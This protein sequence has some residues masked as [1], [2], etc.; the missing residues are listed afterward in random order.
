MN[1]LL[2][3][4]AIAAALGA[5]SGVAVERT[6]VE[7]LA[8][9]LRSEVGSGRSPALE[10]ERLAVGGCAR[11]KAIETQQSILD[12]LTGGTRQWGRQSRGRYAS[13]V[14]EPDIN[15]WAVAEGIIRGGVDF[16]NGATHYFHPGTQDLLFARGEIRRNSSQVIA[17]WTGTD[18]LYRGGAR[19]VSVRGLDPARI[20][21]FGP[22]EGFV[23]NA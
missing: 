11:N 2:F 8:R 9:M 19:E 22:P 21:F 4:A 16:A 12:L 10:L 13:T 15:D 17:E 18:R 14:I 7:A 5:L 23:A 1:A 6:D 20:M 3:L